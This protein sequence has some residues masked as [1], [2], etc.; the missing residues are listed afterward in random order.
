M[1]HAR[2]IVARFN[3]LSDKH[4]V[5]RS[6]KKLKGREPSMFINEQFPQ[7]IERKRRAHRPIVN[8]S[9]G[10]CNCHAILVKDKISIKGMAYCTDTIDQI[11][12]DTSTSATRTIGNRFLFSGVLS[13][14]S[15]FHPC[16]FDIDKP[17]PLPEVCLYHSA[18]TQ[19][20]NISLY[21][22][23]NLGG[24]GKTA[25]RLHSPSNLH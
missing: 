19:S 25:S 7:D 11:P 6:A 14:L 8:T 22:L 16:I 20:V 1:K 10:W 13:P 4:L 18:Q 17:E 21:F 9:K 3:I 24:W 2:D 5:L 15:N 23:L 12:F